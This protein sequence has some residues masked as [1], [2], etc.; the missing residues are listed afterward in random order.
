MKK[1]SFLKTGA[2]LSGALMATAAAGRE[3]SSMNPAASE[4]QGMGKFISNPELETHAPE[5]WL[6]TPVDAGGRFRNLNFPFVP[7]FSS[8]MKWKMRPNP[9]EKEKKAD[10]W[11]PGW[12]ADG[13]FLQHRRDCLVWLGHASF[14][15]RLDGLNMLIDPVF[16]K[17]TV[18]KRLQSS[19]YPPEVWTNIHLILISHDHRDHCD[20]PSLRQLA[21]QNPEAKILSGLGMKKLLS[22]VFPAHSIQE[23]GWYQKFNYPAASI[24]FMPGRH[25]SRRGLGDTNL[26][27][28]GSFYICASRSVYF[29]G[30]SGMDTHFASIPSLHSA[31][32][33]ALMGIG[34]YSPEWFM[35][36]SH[37]SPE[38]CWKSFL[39]LGANML[40]PMH[41]G[42]FDLS[43]EPASEPLRRLKAA[44]NPD[45]LL[46]PSIGETLCL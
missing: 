3:I 22:T 45:K 27:L 2:A 26:R 38:D 10:L 46:L 34:A 21:K 5:N 37:M 42:T 16:G 13:D 20:L 31:P 36:P 24:W 33:F 12:Q 35:H 28:W 41:Y 30:D 44:S 32:D 9:Q 4:G 18:V 19:P 8:V 14:F 40:V 6:G 11:R 29:M 15:L 25:W 1:R 23:A 7:G 17:A 43:D 39:S